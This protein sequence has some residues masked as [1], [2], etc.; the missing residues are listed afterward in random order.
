MS[1]LQKFSMAVA[2]L[3]VREA[4]HQR[5]LL[6]F[7]S[8]SRKSHIHAGTATNYTPARGT[9]NLFP[10]PLHRGIVLLSVRG[11]FICWG[12]QYMFFTII[13]LI[14]LHWRLLDFHMKMSLFNTT[15]ENISSKT[16]C[17]KATDKVQFG[18]VPA[19]IWLFLLPKMKWSGI[20]WS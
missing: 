14:F 9:S 17:F 2:R 5:L 20:I 7:I 16:S 15:V 11:L 13:S 18:A 3:D 6:Y 19:C 4:G 1:H 12:K 10:S 8:S